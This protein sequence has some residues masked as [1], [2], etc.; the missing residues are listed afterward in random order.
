ML[1]FLIIFQFDE[2]NEQIEKLIKRLAMVHNLNNQFAME[3]EKLQK[4]MVSVQQKC[5]QLERQYED[6]QKEKERLCGENKQ[7]L[8]D[9][10]MMKTLIY[11]L[12]VQLEQYQE[13]IRKQHKDDT[14]RY[15]EQAIYAN[16]EE[17]RF[18]TPASA[19]NLAEDINWGSVKSHTLAP[20]LNAYQETINEKTTLIDQYETELNRMSGNVKDVLAE[21][22]RLHSEMDELKRA[23][24]TWMSD[25]TRLQAQLD[26]CR[27]VCFC[28][29]HK[30]VAHILIWI[31]S[32]K[33]ETHSKRADLAKEKLVEVLRCYEQ[34]IQSQNLDLERLQEAYARTK[35]ELTSYKNMQ[36]QPEV[37][38]ESLKECQ[39]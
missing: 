36:Q 38:V 34:K 20:L 9:V 2:K 8:D 29:K 12:N 10:K 26:I 25:K 23:N 19:L 14:G 6:A 7:L 13:K 35:G 21:N 30:P 3:H 15:S 5:D 18:A 4:Q 37:V 31:S 39:K 22:E 33:A 24:E 1:N 16:P 27:W 17:I 28:M 11:R 32:E